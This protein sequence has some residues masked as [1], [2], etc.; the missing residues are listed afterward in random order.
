[1]ESC[2]WNPWHG[3]KKYSEGC[4]NCYVY[5]RDES[6]G[7]DAMQVTRN[8]DFSL[9]VKLR[10]DGTYKIPAG[11]EV[12]ACTTSDFFLEEADGWRAEAWQ[13]MRAR[14]DLTFFIITKRI[15]RFEACLPP[16]WGAGYPN[17]IIGCTM[18]NQRQCDIRF[19]VFNA[20]PASGKFVICE[21]LLGPI[22]MAEYLAEQK[23]Q[24]VTVGGES[25]PNARV[26]DYDW[27]LDI[28]RQCVEN[29]I[30]FRFKQTGRLFK[31][32]GKVYTVLRKYQ[33][34]QARKA[35]INTTVPGKWRQ[36]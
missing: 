3:C 27:V 20:I 13:L 22:R 9:P 36:T 5:R 29:Q 1:M 32:D 18:E 34:S 11:T 14:P 25:G 33:H 26:C 24:F 10:R 23:V 12:F 31:K 2:V 7:R 16:D 15:L 21:P 4:Q 30:P 6:V 28:R 8:G 35:G 17:V 19:P